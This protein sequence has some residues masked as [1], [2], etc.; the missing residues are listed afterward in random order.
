MTAKRW[1]YAEITKATEEA[2][3][4]QLGAAKASKARG[5]DSS[6]DIH[7]HFASGVYLLWHKLTLGHQKA[8]DDERMERMLD[9][10]MKGEQ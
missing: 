8:G 7:R 6:H 4:Y 10:S 3:R 9:R 5:A 1:S 2:I